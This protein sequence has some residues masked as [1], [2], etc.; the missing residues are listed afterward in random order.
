M[1]LPHHLSGGFL[2]ARRNGAAIVHPKFEIHA[3]KEIGWRNIE[4]L[5]N[6]F[7]FQHFG[8]NVVYKPGI[9][10]KQQ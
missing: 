6:G 8:N 1:L 7:S 2:C 9:M 10:G 5:N 3:V 4:V